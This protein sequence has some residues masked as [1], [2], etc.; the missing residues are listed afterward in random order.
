MPQIT[1]LP[2]KKSIE[3]QSEETVMQALR[4]GGY[5]IE[6]PCNGKGICGK[7]RVR[8]D[9]PVDLPQTPHRSI[10][11]TETREMGMRL[12]CRLI[13]KGDLSVYL[14]DD[15]TVDARIL[16]GEHLGGIDL[17][18]AAVVVS[19]NN[20]YWLKYAGMDSEVMLP[21]W[22]AQFSPKGLAID[23]GTTTL[24]VTLFCLVTGK[25]LST[26]SSIN[27]QTKFG[28][29]VLSR[30]QKGSTQEGL[31]E[32][33][34]VVRKELNRL[35]QTACQKSNAVVDEVLDG[36]IG[37]NTTML[38]LVA[39]INPESLGHLPFTVDIRGG[40]SYA[41]R[42]F[43]LDINPAGRIYVPPIV[44][45]FIGSDITAGI[46]AC[47]CLEKQKPSLFVDVGTNGE[48][49]INNDGRFIVASTAA[50]PAFEGMGVSCGIRAVPGAVEAAH[51]DG[52][53]ID[54]KT[55]DGQPAR[56][57]CGSG[58]IDMMASLLKADIVNPDGRMKTPEEKE[59]LQVSV[60]EGL[61]LVE[62]RPVFNIADGV[63]F[64]QADIRQLQLAKGAI[65]T[66]IDM[67]M[68]EANV[69]AEDLDDITLAGAFGY[70]L[71]P[72]SLATIG[73]IPEKLAPKVCFAGNTS[74]TGCAM[75]LINAD[76]RDYLQKLV[77]R[78]EHLPLA[79][80]ISFQNLFIENLNFPADDSRSGRTG[81]ED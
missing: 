42:D 40:V 7:C 16:E 81:I 4:R 32:V 79:E 31:T 5:E 34:G 73:L 62:D 75:M 66:G 22:R 54:I 61:R 69:T 10:S 59:G 80:K 1:I 76:L 74:K 47:G 50:G 9:N 53:T 49:G 43:G 46:L 37:G 45:A 25:E 15:F 56:G 55:I 36:V 67:L 70:H 60:A 26:T 58:I 14:P 33:A 57:I 13:P 44:H 23:V 68:S 39:A 52:E 28:H 38:T 19:R 17:N 27:P 64:N 3:I 11:E 77:Q 6:G 51:F 30:I 41:A 63:F 65:R 71:R 21:K 78:V 2:F 24:V 48:M 35:I 8:V 29:D 18:P 72:D 12:A 20:T